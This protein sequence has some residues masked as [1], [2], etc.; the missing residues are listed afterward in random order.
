VNFILKTFS[1]H[2]STFCRNFVSIKYF[3]TIETGLILWKRCFS[4]KQ[5]F[6]RSSQ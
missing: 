6:Y 3:L 2:R 1:D 5:N 4:R